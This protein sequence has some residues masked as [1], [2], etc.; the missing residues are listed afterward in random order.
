M[1]VLLVQLKKAIHQTYLDNR[2]WT[3][4]QLIIPVDDPLC[5]HRF[6]GTEAEVEVISTYKKAL[7]ELQKAQKGLRGGGGGDEEDGEKEDRRPQ[8]R[9]QPQQQQQ[10]QRQAQRQ[11]RPD[12]NAR[13]AAAGGGEGR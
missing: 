10:Q 4:S 11:Q 7:T 12:D 5:R 13:Q 6:G 1:I 3:T 2:D 9:R 8:P